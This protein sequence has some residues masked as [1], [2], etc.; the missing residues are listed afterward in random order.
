MVF[1]IE[2]PIYICFPPSQFYTMA[3][4]EGTVDGFFVYVYRYSL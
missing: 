3:Y 2:A 1:H 4:D